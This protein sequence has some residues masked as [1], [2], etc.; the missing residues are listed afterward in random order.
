MFTKIEQE[1]M[2][3]DDAVQA[4][5]DFKSGLKNIQIYIDTKYFLRPESSTGYAYFVSCYQ[6]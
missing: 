6:I 3:L 4:I 5:N 1:R 2:T